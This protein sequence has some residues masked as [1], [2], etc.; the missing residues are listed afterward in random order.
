[1][2]RSLEH[3]MRLAEIDDR[4]RE[5]LHSPARPI[6]L[7]PVRPGH[8]APAVAPGLADVGVFLPA[9]PLQYLLLQDG[10]PLQVMTSGNV[11]DEPIAR[12]NAEAF[13]HLAGIADVFLVHDREVYTR[14]DDSVVRSSPRGMIPMRRARGFVPDAFALRFSGPAVLA[15]GGHE[16]NTVCL[17][18]GGRAVVSQHVGDLDH[19]DSIAFFREAIAHLEELAGVKADVVVHDLHPDYASTRW[20]MASSRQRI[21]VQHHHAHVAACLAE[22]DRTDR[23]IGIAFDGTGL[24]DDGMLW[25]GEILEADLVSSRRLG[26]LR[27]LALP[28]GE[29]AI[30]EPWRVAAAALLDAGVQLDILPIDPTTRAR[31]LALLATPLPPK[32]SGAGRW[33][34]A[35]AA[36]LGIRDVSY[37][38]QAAA[39]LEALAGTSH[40]PTFEI[41]LTHGE[42]FEIDL[43]PAIRELVHCLR[44][45]ADTA[46]LAARF[47]T[48]LAH[49]T[50]LSARHAG[51]RT[52]V[53]T[54][55]CFQNR[56]LL[57][58]AT[59]LLEE[60]GVEVL[61][62]GRIPPND[63][64]LSLGQ[65]AI[66]AMRT[67]C[68]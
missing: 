47:H 18:H 56:R 62:H 60:D 42:P 68:A 22:H 43:R 21:A 25:G 6:V 9:T 34:D 67:I 50:R 23:V 44:G 13:K 20:A 57:E 5:A 35:V 26:D 36:I 3:V 16:R 59:T 49:A 33:F 48:T 64:G 61:A 8:L 17:A 10:P 2:A 38:G 65:A 19:P 58:L 11:S 15:V 54:G 29:A 41:E 1:M 63:G 53:L 45:G 52:V 7:V 37:D 55:G 30:R 46:L 66:A 12:T 31:I 27:R 4:A 28:G 39:E 51:A 32:A 14:T 40:G 24:G